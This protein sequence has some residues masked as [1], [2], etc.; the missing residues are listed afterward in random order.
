MRLRE[1]NVTKEGIR[2][3]KLKEFGRTFC[4]ILFQRVRFMFH[5]CCCA[6]TLHFAPTLYVNK[7]RS[8]SDPPSPRPHRC[9]FP[10]PSTDTHLSEVEL[11]LL[12]VELGLMQLDACAG[13][14]LGGAEVDPDSPEAFEHLERC[15]FIIDPEQCLE[16]LLQNMKKDKNE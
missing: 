2:R 8:A 14:C 6:H 4:T 5:V 16:P 7:Q 15:L 9:P 12:A 11:K 1:A 3:E 10:D 13:R